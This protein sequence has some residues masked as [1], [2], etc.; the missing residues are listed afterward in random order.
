MNGLE[1]GVIRQQ[2]GL[3]SSEKSLDGLNQMME[4]FG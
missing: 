3:R 4:Y 2:I 1:I